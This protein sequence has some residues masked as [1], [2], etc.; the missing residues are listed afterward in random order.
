MKHPEMLLSVDE[1]GSNTWQTSD[2]HAAG[3]LFVLPKDEFGRGILGSM[4]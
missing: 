1:A 2:R 4:T 3:Q